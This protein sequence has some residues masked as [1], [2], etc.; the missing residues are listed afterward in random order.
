MFGAIFLF[1]LVDVLAK[2]VS[3][4]Y[5]ANEI[6]FFRMLFGLIPAAFFF[7]IGNNSGTGMSMPRLT[8]HFLR[9]I[10]ALGSMGFFFASLTYLSL[11]TAVTLQYTE[12][13]FIGVLAVLFLG[14]RFR[15]AS[16]AALATGFIGV[17]LVSTRLGDHASM[18]GIVLTL[19]SALFGAGS[20]I[21]IKRLART[22][23][24]AAIVLYFTAIG[25]VMSGLSLMMYWATPSAIDLTYMALLG[26]A[27]GSGQLLFTFAFRNARASF[28]APFGYFGIIWAIVFGYVIWGEAISLQAAL[29]SVIIVASALYLGVAKET[30]TEGRAQPYSSTT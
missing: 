20:A 28:L 19:L 16:I 13:I 29:G 11:A 22:E 10:M 21:Q 1:S 7:G 4:H 2:L 3:T 23:A 8:G 27:A 18:L 6:T 25:T 9:A 17:F 12:A 14:E 5:P 24:P 15:M 26:I 30:K